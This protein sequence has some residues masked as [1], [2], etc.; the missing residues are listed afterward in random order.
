MSENMEPAPRW[1][2]R[3]ARAAAWSV[4]PS[5]LWRVALGVGLPVG[6]HGDLER[7]FGRWMPGWGTVYV[8][9]LSALAE[10]LAFLTIGLVR[11][12]GRRVPRWVPAFGG[13]I[14]PAWVALFPATLGA[15]AVTAV[16]WSA[17]MGPWQHNMSN[18]DSPH[19]LAGVVMTLCYL[20]LVA[21]GPLLAAV[22]VD[23]ARRA[24]NASRVVAVR[25]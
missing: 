2:V 25:V 13:R 19:G 10:A 7:M 16:T 24:H 12:W 1:A 23:H 4:V 21:W 14:F 8:L 6:F 5:G 15:L 3:A 9:A 11:P 17:A 18:P 22:T 20:P